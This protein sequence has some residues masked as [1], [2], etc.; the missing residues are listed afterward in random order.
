MTFYGKKKKKSIIITDE[1]QGEK[2][3]LTQE[4]RHII[5]R[6]LLSRKSQQQLAINISWRQMIGKPPS[7][8]G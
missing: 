5:D 2:N 8:R 1:K 7:W 3:E 4:R 6:I